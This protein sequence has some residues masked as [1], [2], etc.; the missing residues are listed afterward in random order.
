MRQLPN[1]MARL[2]SV[3]SWEMGAVCCFLCDCK[4]I[5]C[6]KDQVACVLLGLDFP[7]SVTEPE[8]TVRSLHDSCHILTRSEATLVSFWDYLCLCRVKRCSNVMSRHSI[9][10]LC[11]RVVWPVRWLVR[12]K[13]LQRITFWRGVCFGLI[14]ELSMHA[15]LKICFLSLGLHECQ[16]IRWMLICLSLWSFILAL[17]HSTRLVPHHQ[18]RRNLFKKYLREEERSIPGTKRKVLYS[19]MHKPSKRFQD[20]GR[21]KYFSFF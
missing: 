9:M 5:L 16:G 15:W 7:R 2:A 3:W 14:L 10:P 21:G 4:C 17:T 8:V 13:D 20:F 11:A 19:V 18:Q 1:C 6:S 12:W